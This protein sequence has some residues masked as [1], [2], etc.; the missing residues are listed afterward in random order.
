MAYV[1]SDNTESHLSKG[2]VVAQTTH[3]FTECN[4]SLYFCNTIWSNQDEFSKKQRVMEN[5]PA[6]FDSDST[7]TDTPKTLTYDTSISTVPTN[8]IKNGRPFDKQPSAQEPPLHMLFPSNHL[9]LITAF[10]YERH[11]GLFPFLSTVPAEAEHISVRSTMLKQH[12]APSNV[13]PHQSSCTLRRPY[14]HPSA[15]TIRTLPSSKK[16][17]PTA[18]RGSS[19]A[20]E[21]PWYAFGVCKRSPLLT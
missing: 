14:F 6:V 19:S 2:D 13:L 15:L 4:E 16:P 11:A 8:D 1:T 21:A 17:F 3:H 20:K 5:V 12:V 10:S 18:K 7:F 9:A